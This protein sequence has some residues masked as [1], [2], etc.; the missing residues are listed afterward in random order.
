[1][2]FDGTFVVED[3]TAACNDV[4]NVAPVIA[5]QR[6]AAALPT[7]HGG[8]IVDGTYIETAYTIYTGA[9]GAMGPE[10]MDHQFTAVIGGGTARVAFLTNGVQKR[11][12]FRI[13]TSGTQTTWT[14]TCPPTMAP[15]VYGFD[16][17]QTQIMLYITA[18][19]TN[20]RTF[21]LSRQ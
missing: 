1:V 12:T 13:E 9:G 5:G 4:I 15:I 17:S 2:L 19:P 6:V 8:T 21:T 10:G 14:F 20:Q 7:P 18:D 3:A 16:A 11:Y